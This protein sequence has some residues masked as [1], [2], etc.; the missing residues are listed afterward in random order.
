MAIFLCLQV[1]SSIFEIRKG[2][3]YIKWQTES[4][5]LSVQ[6]IK[7]AKIP[8]NWTI[9]LIRAGATPYFL[10][11]FVFDDMLGKSDVFI[12]HSKVKWGPPGH[13]KW[14]LDYSLS[15]L[16]PNLIIG[17]YRLVPDDDTAR[18]MYNSKGAYAFIPEMWL[19]DEF[20]KHY[21]GND[22][23]YSSEYARKILRSTNPFIET[24]TV[25]K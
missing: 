25:R 10:N 1:G 9:A 11:D 12:A 3:R 8:N 21:K 20:K 16:K 14:D 6:L 22:L 2:L 18:F 24:V 7:L 5:L 19:N 17:E 23:P 15:H 4:S 13:N